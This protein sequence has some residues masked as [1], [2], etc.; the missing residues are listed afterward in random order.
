MQGIIWP[1]AGALLAVAVPTAA[2]AQSAPATQ[3]AD[4]AELAEARA[5]MEIAFP[6]SERDATFGT[7]V[8]QLLEQYRQAIPL[9]MLNDPGLEELINAH[10]DSLPERLMPT[11]KVHLPRIVDATAVAYTN[12]F[13]LSELKEIHAFAQTD[14]G[15]H[16]LSESAKLVGDPAVAAANT[17]YMRD[18]QD[19]QK[20]A[21]EALR[22]E[23][24][25]YLE[26]NPEVMEKLQAA[27]TN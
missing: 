22:Q 18:L 1:V 23:V 17:A 4:T 10:L 9:N 14:T 12:E 24:V 13:S 19:L 3:V 20:G 8:G 7:M 21:T 16:Y 6:T 26:A 15:R 2:S 5:I 25:A 27:S 11:L